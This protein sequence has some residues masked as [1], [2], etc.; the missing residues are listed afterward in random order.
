MKR[1]FGSLDEFKKGNKELFSQPIVKSFFEENPTNL[2]LLEAS[3]I[4]KI[5]EATRQLDELFVEHFFL[6]RLMKYIK[7]IMYFPFISNAS[8]YSGDY[9]S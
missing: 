5:E 2:T 8:K 3:V 9:S 1:S 6:Y 4:Y 7:G